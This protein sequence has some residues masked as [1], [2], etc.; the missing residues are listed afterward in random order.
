MKNLFCILLFSSS[1]CMA[2]QEPQYTMY[3][4][5]YSIF[6]PAASG[7][8]YDK[9][10]AVT[11][12][13]QWVG[14]GAEPKTLAAQYCQKIDAIHGGAGINYFYDELGLEKKHHINLNYSFHLKLKN[15]NILSFGLY[16][17][18][19]RYTIDRT[20]FV[21]ID[22]N[23]PL[24]QNLKKETD[25]NFNSGFG[26][27]FKTHK[28]QAGA[29]IS[30]LN[31]PKFFSPSVKSSRHYYLSSLYNIDLYKLVIQ[32]NLL[33]KTTL[34]NW[35]ID[36]SLRAFFIKHFWLGTGWRYQD[37]IMFMAGYDFKEKFRIGYSYDYTTSDIGHF[38]HGSHELTLA[39]TLNKKK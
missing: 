31:E 18:I 36:V 33:F 34:K 14:F 23:D 21:F 26:I 24:L 32:P 2:Q 11:S 25:Y 7:L 15:D 19:L 22:P 8:F 37:A 28:Y 6:N 30:Q 3:W 35:Q 5:Q 12:R 1:L 17:G 10:A 4:N 9:Y 29:G 13:H 16:A 20:Q 27:V 39:M 38:S